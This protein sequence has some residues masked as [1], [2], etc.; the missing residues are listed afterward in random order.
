MVLLCSPAAI[1]VIIV[2]RVLE[3]VKAD[4]DGTAWVIKHLRQPARGAG[5]D[6][7]IALTPQ[8]RHE[9]GARQV[10]QSICLRARRLAVSA[11]SDAHVLTIYQRKIARAKGLQVLLLESFVCCPPAGLR[12][13]SM[14]KF[15]W[16]G[17]SA[18]MSNPVL[19]PVTAQQME[20]MVSTQWRSCRNKWR[21]LFG[22]SRSAR[23]V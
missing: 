6:K 7:Y 2:A 14:F 22:G 17:Q 5:N 20:Q 4:E 16:L 23:I 21:S 8:D 15:V 19:L 12:W 18:R 11:L 1:R 9:E 13:L 3:M 10:P